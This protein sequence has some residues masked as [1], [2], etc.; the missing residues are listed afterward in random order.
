MEQERPGGVDQGYDRNNA[1]PP[2][3]FLDREQTLIWGV[4]AKMAY[5]RRGKGA[6]IECSIGGET[7]DG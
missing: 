2:K 4:F 1:K 7:S 5:H 6:C 3:K